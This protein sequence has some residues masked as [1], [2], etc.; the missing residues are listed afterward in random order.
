MEDLFLDERKSRKRSY[1]RE[2]GSRGIG[3]ELNNVLQR[4]NRIRLKKT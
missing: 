4:V 2:V 3:N 1:L